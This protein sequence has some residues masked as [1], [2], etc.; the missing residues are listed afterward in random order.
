[1]FRELFIL[2]LFC[3]VAQSF[4]SVE[5]K[6]EPHDSFDNSIIQERRKAHLAQTKAN[7]KTCHAEV[8]ELPHDLIDDPDDWTKLYNAAEEHVPGARCF[9]NCMTKFDEPTLFDAN[10]R[11]NL[12]VNTKNLF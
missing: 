7:F 9:V 11:L 6:H 1:M 5:D 12:E 10:G 8:P 4:A 2:Y 3:Y